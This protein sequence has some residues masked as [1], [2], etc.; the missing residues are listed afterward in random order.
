M[1]SDERRS[2]VRRKLEVE[3]SLTSESN[4]FAGLSGDVSSGGIFVSTYELR[5]VG[6]KLDLVFSLAETVIEARGTVRW[7]QE[8]REDVSPGMGV[9]FDQLAEH[10]RRKIEAFCQERAPLYFDVD[11]SV[12][13][14]R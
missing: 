12:E 8:P 10:D 9:K 5:P 7:V 1:T 2:A 4:F 6:T 14:R 3:V 13:A 11:E